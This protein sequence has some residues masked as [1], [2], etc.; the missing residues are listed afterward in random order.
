MKH[1]LLGILIAASAAFAPALL[2]A[3][4]VPYKEGHV[5]DVA[6]IKIKQ[7]KFTEY[8]NFLQTTWRQE[9]EEAKKQGL[10]VSYAVYEA[11]AHNPSEP[12]L[13]LVTE[14]ANMAAFD[15]LDAKMTAIDKKL[16]GGSVKA[17]EQA[18]SDR[19]QIRTVLGDE[20][21]RELQFK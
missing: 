18:Q 9:M 10:I 15:G 2:L 4:D 14:Y 12:D 1:K 17:A 16:A 19:D 20:L 5:L 11:T 21:I 13:F 7:G 8:W 3:D 6:S